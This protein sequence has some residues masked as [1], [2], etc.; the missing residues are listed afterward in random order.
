MIFNKIKNCII[1][2]LVFIL[3]LTLNIY[4]YKKYKTAAAE[5]KRLEAE[6]AALIKQEGE[7]VK[8]IINR[9]EE[10]KNK[11]EELIYYIKIL[12]ANKDSDECLSSPV[13]NNIRELLYEAGI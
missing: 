3:I 4:F 12:E 9:S 5:I 11:N 1:S 2:I 13:G 7:L 8:D 10:L 6:Q